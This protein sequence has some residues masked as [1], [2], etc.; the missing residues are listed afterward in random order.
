MFQ[1]GL[2]YQIVVLGRMQTIFSTAYFQF[3]KRFD[4][5]YYV[6]HM[7]DGLVCLPSWHHGK[8]HKLSWKNDGVLLSDFCG[9]LE[10]CASAIYFS[11]C[12]G[13]KT[14]GKGLNE[15]HVWFVGTVE[16]LKSAQYP[17]HVLAPC[18]I[19]ISL[20]K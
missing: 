4:F 12:V 13:K 8:W 20:E 3:E 16:F 9:N 1:S 14:Y 11:L 19:I 17:G 10:L 6:M 15:V 5:L 7:R 18:K 2:R